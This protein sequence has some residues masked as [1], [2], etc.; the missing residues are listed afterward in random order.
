VQNR[1]GPINDKEYQIIDGWALK[2]KMDRD[3]TITRPPGC[4]VAEL[5]F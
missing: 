4:S 3:A 5:G 2:E 1:F